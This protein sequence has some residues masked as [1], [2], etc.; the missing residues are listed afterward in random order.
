MII[1]KF[2]KCWNQRTYYLM[3]RIWLMVHRTDTGQ[4]G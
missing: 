1:S 3:I 2:V 4:N